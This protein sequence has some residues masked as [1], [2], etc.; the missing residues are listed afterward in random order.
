MECHLV[1]RT[2]DDIFLPKKIKTEEASA[3]I[4][5]DDSDDDDDDCFIVTTTTTTSTPL[6]RNLFGL[7]TSDPL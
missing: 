2:M 6:T 4:V 7:W 5:I 3:S 1:N